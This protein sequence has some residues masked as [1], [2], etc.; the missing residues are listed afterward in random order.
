MAAFP[1]AGEFLDLSAL[2]AGFL[3]A[4]IAIG[5]FI[6]HTQAVLGSASE[7]ELQRATAIGG[8]CGLLIGV[9]I[10]I[11]DAIGG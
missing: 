3:A 6:G 5:G 1:I 10:V 9:T 2:G 7:S 8:L 11:G 4:A